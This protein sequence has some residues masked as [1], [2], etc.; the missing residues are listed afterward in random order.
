MKLCYLDYGMFMKAD[1]L[2]V[3]GGPDVSR[4]PQ[5]SII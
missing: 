3:S 1:F 2:K 5:I 4:V